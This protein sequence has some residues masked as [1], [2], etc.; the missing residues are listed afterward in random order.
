MAPIHDSDV[1][2][3]RWSKSEWENYELWEKVE[4]KLR[5][6]KRLW[7]LATGMVVICFSAIPIVI[8]RWPKWKT[9]TATRY[10]A[11]EI[12]SMKREAS[13]N[14][15]SYRVVFLDG[16]KLEFYIEKVRNC[17]DGS[18]EKV[19][20]SDFNRILPS[21]EYTLIPPSVGA[22]LGV[23]GLIQ[24]FCYDYLVGSIIQEFPNRISGFGIISVKDLAEKR[25]DRASILLL[26][27][28]SAELSFD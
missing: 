24:R 10:L 20:Y 28:P 1:S 12:N 6:K 15:S 11:Q 4:S 13:M 5:R 23:P 19:H 3:Q 18:G 22:G 21:S 7:I 8:D 27:G 2:E 16:Q 9:R 17:S 26:S 25:L 14:R